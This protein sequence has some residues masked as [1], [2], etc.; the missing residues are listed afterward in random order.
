MK[1]TFIRP[2]IG[3]LESARYVDSGRMEPLSLAYIAG[4]TPDDIEKVMYDDRMEAIPYDEPTD[5]VAITVQVFTA[6]RA[7]QISDRFRKIGVPVVMGGYHPT[8]IPEEAALHAD[9]VVT[10]DAE[11]VWLRL[12]DDFRGAGL[13]KFYRSESPLSLEDVRVDRNIFRGKR[14]LPADLVQFSR[15][16]PNLC[17][18]CATGTIYNRE[19]FTRP[20]RMVA[21]EVE[22][23]G[24]RFVFFVDDNI[25]ADREASKQLFREIIPLKIKWLGQASVDFADDD[26]LI[27]LMAASGCTGLVVG[28]ESIDRENLQQMGKNCNY[29]FESYE[30]LIRKIRDHGIMIWAAFLLGYD[31]DTLETID[32]TVEFALRH[33]F[34]FAAFNNLLPYPSTE[35]YA[36][37]KREG[38]L[39]DEKWW[40]D[41]QFYIGCVPFRPANMSAAEMSEACWDARRKFNSY[42]SIFSRWFDRSTNFRNPLNA[43]TFLRYNLLFRSEVYMKRKVALGNSP[44]LEDVPE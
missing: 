30:P 33:R 36:T 24:K 21:E 8:M 29:Q 2:N 10:G 37:L 19:Y 9:A 40:L 12:L 39:I 42:R 34:A 13:K 5:L 7:Y 26:E 4:L 11:G 43:L 31:H 32:A 28:F 25:V 3:S 16:C 27:G 6:R 18:F 20:T 41:P 23:L 44:V 35:L 1:I 15:G 38:R 22:S 14:Y 17:N